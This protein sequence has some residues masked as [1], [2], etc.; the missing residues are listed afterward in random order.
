MNDRISTGNREADEILCGGFP[1]NSINIIMGLPGTGKTVF[2]QNLVFHNATGERP[3]LYLTTLSEPVAK[4]I[5]YLER[6]SFYDETKLGTA[7]HYDDI[8]ARLATEGIGAMIP[9][10]EEAI[11]TL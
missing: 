9:V 3:I 11:K 4:V 10:I 7:V 2:A 8:G 1:K 6:F 5:R